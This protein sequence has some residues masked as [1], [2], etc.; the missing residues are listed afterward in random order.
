MEQPIHEI[1]DDM[2]VQFVSDHKEKLDKMKEDSIRSIGQFSTIMSSDVRILG[3]YFVA[4]AMVLE[5]DMLV[6]H[7]FFLTPTFD[8]LFTCRVG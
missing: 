6:L 5:H 3:V 1:V 2:L 8:K 4:K 7:Y